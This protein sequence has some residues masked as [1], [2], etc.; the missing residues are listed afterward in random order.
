MKREKTSYIIRKVVQAL[1]VMEQF[2]DDTHELGVVELGRRL[3]LHP[4]KVFRLLATLESRDYVEQNPR[5]EGYRLGFKAHQLGQAFLKQMGLL[6]QA[7]PVQES[8][9]RMC[10][11]TSCVS[12]MKDFHIVCLDAVESDLPVRVAPRIGIRSPLHCTGAG[13]VRAANLSEAELEKYLLGR[14]L[15]RFTPNTIVDHDEFA[16]QLRET[17]SL[18]YAVNHEE[19][20]LGVTCIGA[21]LRDRTGAVVGAVSVSG[22]S[23]R[24]APQRL[25]DEL[26]PLVKEAA[27]VISLRLGCC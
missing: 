1:E 2:K 22:P 17:A 7:R 11:E 5:T 23:V 9:V 3:K 18:G 26:I 27:H 20:E 25:H 19:S 16:G 10:R 21:P 8:L 24:M 15:K 14:E 4:S 13:K 12:I 6:R